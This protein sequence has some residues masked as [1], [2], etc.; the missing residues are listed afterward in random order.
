MT[1]VV[2]LDKSLEDWMK[3][4]RNRTN[5]EKNRLDSFTSKW[6]H[7]YHLDVSVAQRLAKAGFYCDVHTECF[8]HGLCLVRVSTECF[9][10]GL[11]IPPY[12]WRE[13]HDPEAIHRTESPNCLFI[14][15]QSGNVPIGNEN[16]SA[17]LVKTDQHHIGKENNTTIKQAM[18]NTDSNSM[19][20]QLDVMKRTN[21]FSYKPRPSSIQMR[22]SD[23][24]LTTY[25]Q[26][27]LTSNTDTR[28]TE[29]SVKVS[30][31]MSCY[32]GYLKRNRVCM[33]INQYYFK[34]V[35]NAYVLLSISIKI[36]R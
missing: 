12:F 17:R 3:Q 26:Q 8:S 11:R 22:E 34:Q 1:E 13:E 7:Y 23:S 29:G 4:N 28:S 31:S 27:R 32:L 24:S 16:P 21:K 5:Y 15:S 20:N 35:F 10:C 36:H 19:G 6:L 2:S 33:E 14:N 30:V 25:K 9:S 18:T